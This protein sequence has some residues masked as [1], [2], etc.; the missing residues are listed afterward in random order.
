MVNYH[1]F[2]LSNLGTLPL[3]PWYKEGLEH[4]GDTTVTLNFVL[5]RSLATLKPAHPAPSTTTRGRGQEERQAG[6]SR[7]KEEGWRMLGFLL[8]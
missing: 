6:C 4:L 1:T 3:V 8:N 7:R 5:S 2:A